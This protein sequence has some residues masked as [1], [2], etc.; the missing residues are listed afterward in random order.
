MP[1]LP[2][3]KELTMRRLLP[4]LLMLAGIAAAQDYP[5]S[6]ASAT[7][8]GKLSAASATCANPACLWIVVPQDTGAVSVQLSGTFTATM[9]FEVSANGSN[10]ISIG[11][12]ATATSAT[13]AGVYDFVLHGQRYFRVRCSSYSSG[14]VAADIATRKTTIGQA[15]DYLEVNP[16]GSVT[17][18]NTLSAS[19][20]IGVQFS[21]I[22]V[23]PATLA[24]GAIAGYFNSINNGGDAAGGVNMDSG[25]IHALIRKANGAIIHA[26]PAVLTPGANGASFYSINDAGDAAGEA[27]NDDGSIWHAVIRKANGTIIDVAPATLTPGA[28]R[29]TFYS[30][31]NAGDVAGWAH[32]GNSSIDH[33]VIRKADGTIIDAAPATLIA[34]GTRASFAAINAVGDAAGSA[35]NGSWHGVIRK[36]DGTVI[37]VD[38]AQLTSINAA[39]E[40]AGTRDGD[41]AAI[42]RKA[43]GTIIDIPPPAWATGIE[44]V[45]INAAGDAAGMAYNDSSGATHGLIRKA[46]GTVIDI[47]PATTTTPGATL[48]NVYSI[49]DAGD[50]AGDSLNDNYTINHPVILPLAAVATATTT[51]RGLIQPADFGRIPM[52]N[53]AKAP[54]VCSPSRYGESYFS[55]TDLRL[56]VCANDGVSD[57]WLKSNDYSS[58]TGHCV[59]P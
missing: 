58:A 15:G 51:Q 36:A 33:A 43:D 10:W 25:V 11:S 5:L 41:T 56:C 39:G 57:A 37:S 14:P 35:Y 12:T 52:A 45:S 24:S 6:Y 50:V 21:A 2:G 22:D 44:L 9:Q 3:I 16:D 53:S 20:V 40:V 59:V 47:N 49:N 34:G 1:G 4:F 18:G 26:V 8:S 42:I 29:A 55:L 13:A 31:N 54:F 19:R 30:I 38:N 48:L 27:T 23:D 7:A 46:D 32:N 28:T 17:I